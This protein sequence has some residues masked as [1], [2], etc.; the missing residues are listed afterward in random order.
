[1]EKA[2]L[3]QPN[4]CLLQAGHHTRQ[5]RNHETWTWCGAPGPKPPF[6]NSA[7]VIQSQAGVKLLLPHL[8]LQFHLPIMEVKVVAC[9]PIDYWTFPT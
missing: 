7:K 2:Y 1:M 8:C 5:W 6:W 4:E 3:F 9:V